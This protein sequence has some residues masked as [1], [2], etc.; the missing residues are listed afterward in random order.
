MLP[1]GRSE[2]IHAKRRLSDGLTLIEFV[3]CALLCV[4]AI[5]AFKFDD[6]TDEA[7]LAALPT[8]AAVLTCLVL[9]VNVWQLMKCFNDWKQTGRASWVSIGSWFISIGS[10]FTG[11]WAPIAMLF[12]LALGIPSWVA[13]DGSAATRRA[14][15]MAV[16]NTIWV[17]SVIIVLQIWATHCP[18]LRV[19]A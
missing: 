8:L 3:L 2:M 17:F 9:V 6:F 11:P 15:R 5:A 10:W 19:I 7:L 12:S 4:A 16:L 13:A 18:D 1:V 14:G